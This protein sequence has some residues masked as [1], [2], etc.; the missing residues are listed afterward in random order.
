MTSFERDDSARRARL[1]VPLLYVDAAVLVAVTVWWLRP[2]SDTDSLRYRSDSIWIP[3]VVAGAL[4][5][6]TAGLWLRWFH[7]VAKR[8]EATGR[9]RF[10]D[11]W[12]FWG[13]VLPGVNLVLPK[14]M[15][16]DIWHAADERHPDPMPV[17]V[18]WWWV[19]SV[20]TGVVSFAQRR[21]DWSLA[22][23]L[24]AYLLAEA[25]Q[26]VLGALVV[27]RLTERDRLLGANPAVLR[28]APAVQPVS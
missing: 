25:A 18:A 17:V 7:A 23:I 9:T 5:L 26:V 27:R 22:A 28:P 11:M 24:V 13:W 8:A 20:V 15:V 3:I 19:F 21:Y 4:W 2:S 10:R 16:N 14:M 6:A 12:W 1:L